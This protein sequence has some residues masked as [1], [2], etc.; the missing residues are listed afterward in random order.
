MQGVI[1]CHKICRGRRI[2]RVALISKDKT[3]DSA[4][5]RKDENIVSY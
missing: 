1:G 3:V 5:P 2:V 4:T